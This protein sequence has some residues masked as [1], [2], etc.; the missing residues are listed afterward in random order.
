MQANPTKAS[1]PPI[2][3]TIAQTCLLQE[4]IFYDE[5]ALVEPVR[6]VRFL[7]RLGD[8][9]E[10]TPNF[11]AECIQT[12]F[13]INGRG[14]SAAPGTVIPYKVEDTYGRPWAAIWEEH[15]EE[16]MQRPATSDIFGFE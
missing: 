3:Q 1:A 5:Y 13:P 6:S 9:N 11:L 2:K 7:P 16:G 10:V 8:L 14:T 4:T 15:F 12:I